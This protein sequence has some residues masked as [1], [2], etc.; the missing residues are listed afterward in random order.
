M[1]IGA[2]AF[3]CE[4]WIINLSDYIY[5][6]YTTSTTRLVGICFGHQIIARALG[7]V[8]EQ[9]PKGWEVSVTALS[10]DS[11][12]IA[13]KLFPEAAQVGELILQEMH[14]DHVATV[15][16]GVH[17]FAS[18]PVSPVQGM[19]VPKKLLTLQGHPEFNSEVARALVERVIRDGGL[20]EE[21]G[22]DALARVEKKNHGG[23][24]GKAVVRFLS[25][26]LDE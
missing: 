25:G 14:R 7:G 23:A 8:V 24:V 9:N 26:V 17:I 6:A 18:S 12:G 13:A 19:F 5:K 21:Q 20:T 1:R 4:K 2:T 16:D 15:P 11:E 10:M 22:K 3:D